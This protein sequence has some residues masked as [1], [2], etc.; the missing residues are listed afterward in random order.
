MTKFFNPYG[1][2]DGDDMLE[3]LDGGAVEHMT[4]LEM[5]TQFHLLYGAHIEEKP[6]LD[7][8]ESLVLMRVALIQEEFKELLEAIA[9]KDLIEFADALADMVYVIYGFA[10]TTGVNLDRVLAEVHRSNLSKLGEDGEPI[11]REDGKVLKGPN[12][13]PPDIKEVLGLE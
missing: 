12:W 10:V 1:P 8:P 13:R 4:P 6:T 2:P 7:I 5:V 3:L 9:E 11:Y